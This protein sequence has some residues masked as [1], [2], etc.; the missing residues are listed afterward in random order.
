MD[1]GLRF[2]VDVKKTT[3]NWAEKKEIKIWKK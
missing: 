2:R 1:V 3:S